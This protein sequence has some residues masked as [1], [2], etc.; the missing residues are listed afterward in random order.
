MGNLDRLLTMAE[1]KGKVLE[2]LDN[3]EK[4][5]TKESTLNRE[6]HDLFFKRIRKLEQRPAFSINPVGWLLS[7]LGLRR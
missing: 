3:I 4:Q 2:S 5:A 1:F 7:L 6:Q